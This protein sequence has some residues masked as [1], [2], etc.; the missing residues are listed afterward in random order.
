MMPIAP[1]SPV[2]TDRLRY[3][4]TAGHDGA[5]ARYEQVRQISALQRQ[6]HLVRA[7]WPRAHRSAPRL[8]R[9]ALHRLQP[10]APPVPT[11]SP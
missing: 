9:R 3:W 1:V 6:W 2:T 7:V 11:K 4:L 5:W 10:V 8:P